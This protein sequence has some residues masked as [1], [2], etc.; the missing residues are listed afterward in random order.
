MG[1]KKASVVVTDGDQA[2]CCAIREVLPD[3]AH[4]LCIWHIQK[5]AVLNRELWQMVSDE[6]SL[7]VLLYFCVLHSDPIFP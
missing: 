7:R 4:R 6:I 5:N 3:A 2:M 1:N